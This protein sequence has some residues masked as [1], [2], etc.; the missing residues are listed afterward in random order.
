MQKLL[1][2]IVITN[3]V[4]EVAM[5]LTRLK[6]NSQNRPCVD[7]TPYFS[8]VITSNKRNV[9]QT[10]YHITVTGP[11]EVMWDSGV[12]ESDKS[13]FVEYSGK[14]LKSLCDYIWTVEV[15]DNT[16]ERAAASSSFETGFVNKEWTAEWVKSPIPMKKVKPG[17]GGQ[18]PAEYFRKEF[19]VQPGVKRARVYATCHGAYQ[20][21]MNGIR[22]DDREFAPEFTVYSKYLCYQTYDVT[23]LLQEGDNAIGMLVGDGWYNSENFKPRDKKF[24]AEH[25]VL[26]QIKID[27][28]DGTS[29]MV[30]SDGKVKVSESPVR[31]SDL[32]AG[33]LYDA[34]MEQEGWN[35]PGFDD[36]RWKAAIPSGKTYANLVAQYGEPVRPVKEVPAVGMTVSP[37]GETIIDFG[38]NLAGVLRVK[39]ELP[40]GAKIVLDHFETLDQYGNYFNNIF[41]AEK[42]GHKQS[43]IY[44]SNGKTA[45]YIPH[46]TYHGFRYVRVTCD[47]PVQ[48]GDF[49]AI[50]LS[51][52][53][54]DLGFFETSHGDIN[55]L[56]ENTRWSQRSNML[57]IPTDCPQREKGGWT[58]DIQIYARTA[59]LNENV[60]PFLTRW[61]RNMTCSQ[62]KNGA[63]P[64]VIPLTGIYELLEKLNRFIYHN[65]EPVG[66][67][68]WGD[69][70][71]IIPWS[72]YQLTGNI[73]ILKEQY[74]TMKRWC[75]YIITTAEKRRGKMKHPKEIDRYLWNT[76]H[77]YGEW[78]IPSQMVNGMDRS[79][80]KRINTSV[81]CAP[82]FGWNSCRIM[83]ETAA[84]LGHTAEEL[85]Y[86]DIAS[87]MKSAIQK[88]LIDEDGRMPL[89]MMGSYVLALAFDLAPEKKK[90][91]IA[92]HLI[93]KIEEN[94]D[95]LDTGFL[96]TPYLLDALCKI[97]RI[98]KAYKI[99]LQTKCP[100]WLYEVKQ[101]ATTIWE[102]YISYNEDGSPII[103]SLNHYAFG[104]V[105]DWMFRKIGGIDMAAPGFKK[106]VIA[107]EP[108]N[109]FTSVKRTYMS[110]YG[111][112]GAQWSMTDGNFKIKAEIPCNTTAVVR[113]P[114][115]SS[116]EVGSGVYNFECRV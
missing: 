67:A 62:Q 32:F 104:C 77:Q 40:A 49:T 115:G 9:M 105:D 64:N 108:D 22:P 25:A 74:D 26:F 84:L 31:S 51:S 65:Y 69:A 6:V 85:Y 113:L 18:N 52:D 48:P 19:R 70:A 3:T 38:Q 14:P 81:Y 111:T 45:E 11:E 94:G 7:E 35:C 28:E 102:N 41:H 107:P 109:A 1:K 13:I 83:E 58:G 46:F 34:Q 86:G 75:D 78:L 29:E 15:T 2:K 106:I 61:L 89:D 43:D 100:S 12:V 98:D 59:M 39:T 4:R 112:I 54:E 92:G 20:L 47:V 37:K 42:T 91:S 8:W 30:R 116:H 114:D 56:Y 44:I 110:E 55:R 95:C 99:L 101:G 90:E 93:R 53:N 72:M 5:E 76:G 27:Y 23:P 82:I 73:R 97:G 33:E 68:G 71:C 88:G 21:S 24:K 60:T 96:T 17:T 50:V 57:S 63:I 66:E 10:S 87:R 16:G 36:S 80:V 79:S 103:T